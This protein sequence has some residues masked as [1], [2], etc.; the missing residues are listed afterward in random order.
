MAPDELTILVATFGRATVAEML[1]EARVYDASAALQRGLVHR[2]VADAAVRA[3]ADRTAVHIAALPPL[4]QRIN[5]QTLRQLAAREAGPL[6]E[7]Q[8]AAH[9][10]YASSEEHR[11]AVTKFLAR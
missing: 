3:E 6:S 10:R 2:V 11:D 9:Y 8:R 4:A 5:K 7:T 1:L